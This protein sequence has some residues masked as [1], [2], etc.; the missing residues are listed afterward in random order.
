MDDT[1]LKIV[2]IFSK[3]PAATKLILTILL[4]SIALHQMELFGSS[5]GKAIFRFIN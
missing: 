1:F 4:V 5:V 2:G 3:F